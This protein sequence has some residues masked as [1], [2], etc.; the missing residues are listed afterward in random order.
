MSKAENTFMSKTTSFPLWSLLLMQEKENK[1][2][3]REVCV[4]SDG[5]KS[6][7]SQRREMMT[8]REVVILYKEGLTDK[9][10]S[11][12][13]PERNERENHADI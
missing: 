11:E 4:M 1:Q 2:M 13:R 10:T 3:N 6:Y 5:D 9:M 12:Q 8:D 7:I